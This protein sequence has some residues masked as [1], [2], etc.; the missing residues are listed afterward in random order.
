MEDFHIESI[1]IIHEMFH[2][3]SV[4][5]ERPLHTILEFRY[6]VKLF[7]GSLKNIVLFFSNLIKYLPYLIRS[8]KNLP[9][10]VSGRRGGT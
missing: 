7:W 5:G 8:Q 6:I 2:E 9:L 10:H 1:R 4:L 3:S